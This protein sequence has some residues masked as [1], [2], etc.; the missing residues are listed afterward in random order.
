L[1]VELGELRHG[2]IT[3]DLTDFDR[4]LGENSAGGSAQQTSGIRRFIIGSQDQ[5]IKKSDWNRRPSFRCLKDMQQA[6]R[7]LKQ[8]QAQHSP[9]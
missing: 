6:W 5:W 2:S 9:G 7:P 8:A 1:L 4:D 3:V